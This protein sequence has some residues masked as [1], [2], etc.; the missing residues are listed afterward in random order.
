MLVEQSVN[1]AAVN[2]LIGELDAIVVALNIPKGGLN[3]C[4]LASATPALFQPPSS[5]ANV[6]AYCY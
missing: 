1:V 4:A 6:S 5:H 2:A 3:W